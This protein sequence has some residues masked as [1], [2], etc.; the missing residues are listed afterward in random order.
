MNIFRPAGFRKRFHGFII[1]FVILIATILSFSEVRAALSLLSGRTYDEAHDLGYIDWSGSVGYAN[2]FHRD[3][4]CPSTCV[5][6][7]SQ[8]SNGSQVSGAFDR[9]VG[10]FNVLVAMVPGQGYGTLTLTT[11][12][13]TSSANLNAG[14]GSTPG[15]VKVFVSGVPSTCRTWSASASG[16]TVYLAAVDVTY[17]VPAL[18]PPTI[19]GSLPC[20]VP[21]ANSWCV[22]G[23]S[24]D[25]T[26]SDPQGYSLIISGDINSA[27][28][29]CTAGVTSCSVPISTE[30]SATANFKA[31]SSVALSS[32]GSVVYKLDGT[33]PQLTGTTSGASGNLGWFISD[34]DFSL[35]ATDVV[36]GVALVETR[37]DGGAW[38]TYTAPITLTDG[39]HSVQSRATDYAGNVT[40]IET[41]TINIDTLTPLITP[42]V[43]GVMGL[44]SWYVSSVQVSAVAS[45]TGSGLAT[46]EANVDSGGWVAYT[47]P[48]TLTDGIHSVQFRATDQA[49]N[50]TTSPAQTIQVDTLTPTLSLPITG[51]AGL[52]G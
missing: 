4:I 12:G 23:L 31:T 34:V 50:L 11:C 8:I 49:G 2:I 42:T 16:G 36:S 30:G 6:T 9:D 22:S 13:V 48:I 7:V 32:S 26:A 37:I 18:L 3:S 14:T 39:L 52:N 41:Q 25:L 35:S 17:S 51:T 46:F 40:P 38:T 20:S 27:T 10:S 28:F 15:Y 24:L 45:D 44:N 33:A 19:S 1:F 47:A 29:S 43:S 5:D 21:G